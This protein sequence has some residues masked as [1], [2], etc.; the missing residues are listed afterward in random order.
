[1]NAQIIWKQMKLD[2]TFPAIWK[3]LPKVSYL[4]GTLEW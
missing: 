1:M 3:C 4:R 2:S